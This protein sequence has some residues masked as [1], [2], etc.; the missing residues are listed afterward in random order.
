MAFSN[1]ATDETVEKTFVD[2]DSCTLAVLH[3]RKTMQKSEKSGEKS[4]VGCIEK[5]SQR[6]L[7]MI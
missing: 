1:E 7:G 6:R 2:P 5:M 3:L 4:D